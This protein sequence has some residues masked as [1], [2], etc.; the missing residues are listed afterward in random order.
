MAGPGTLGEGYLCEWVGGWGVR[1]PGTR[2]G[3]CW[4][5]MGSVW[6]GPLVWGEEMW[7]WDGEFGEGLP[8]SQ[9]ELTGRAVGQLWH[10]GT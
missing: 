1:G 8:N 2:Q 10:V 7:G 9:K 3:C 5:L 6:K 4:P